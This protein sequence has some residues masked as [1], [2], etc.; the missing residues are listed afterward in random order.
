MLT[1]PQ[2]YIFNDF[3]RLYLASRRFHWPFD[4]SEAIQKHYSD[5]MMAFTPAFLNAF[6]DL[7]SWRLASTFLDR[8]PEFRISGEVKEWAPE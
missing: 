6:Q 8:Y 3:W 5:T 2:R 4:L 1:N 7:N